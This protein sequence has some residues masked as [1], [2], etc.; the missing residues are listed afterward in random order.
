[1]SSSF[2]TLD[3]AKELLRTFR[4]KH[5]TH[6]E[7]AV[8]GLH[9]AAKDGHLSVGIVEDSIKKSVYRNALMKWIKTAAPLVI[10]SATELEVARVGTL[11]AHLVC[12]D[13]TLSSEDK[14]K[15][16]RCLLCEKKGA[17]QLHVDTA[18]FDGG[19]RW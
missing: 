9:Q 10:Q 16:V 18:F 12:Y 14:E 7:G 17:Y 13:T 3:Q 5:M 2:L 11:D 19:K 8:A 15:Q 4:S 6:A 1:M